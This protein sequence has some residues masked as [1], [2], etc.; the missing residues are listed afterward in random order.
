MGDHLWQPHTH[1]HTHTHG[2]GGLPTTAKISIDVWEDQ[3]GGT[4]GGMTGLDI[5][6]YPLDAISYTLLHG[7]IIII[8]AICQNFLPLKFCT[9]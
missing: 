2:P 9:V 5:S 7:A 8:I 6:D 4:I 3:I 1:T